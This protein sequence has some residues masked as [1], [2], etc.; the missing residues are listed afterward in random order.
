MLARQLGINVKYSAEEG[1]GWVQL[2]P[3]LY[4]DATTRWPSDRDG[5]RATRMETENGD[6]RGRQV[7]RLGRGA[8]GLASKL[9]TG[10][11]PARS[12]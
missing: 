1:E 10:H 4:V 8:I 6:R 12:G 7:I 5:R 11:R 9:E 2:G 3:G